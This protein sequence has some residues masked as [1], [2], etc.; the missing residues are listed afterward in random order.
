M[1]AFKKFIGALAGP[2]VMALLLLLLAAML[3]AFGRRRASLWC[4]IVAGAVA[5]L[6]SAPFVGNALLGAL[7]Q[8]YESLPSE[9]LPQVGYIVVLGSGYSPRDGV[10]ITGALDPDGLT[11]IVEGI[12]LSKT[13]PSAR[14]IVS[15]GAPEG[16]AR[17]ARGYAILARDLGVPETSLQVLDTPLDTAQ[18]AQAI[19][20][21]LKTEKFVLV[22]SAYHMPRA[23]RL[24]RDV[25]AQAIPAPTGQRAASNDGFGWVSLIPSAAG[26]RKTEQALHEYLGLAL[27][28]MTAGR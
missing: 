25:G 11:R 7:E 15:G 16:V 9:Q 1:Y 28:A 14:L 18:E 2:L 24:M 22:T 12:R 10:P 27:A 5:Y 17:S 13:L 6:G 20:G 8:Q 21:M 23:M 19:A 4:V 26:L 3:R